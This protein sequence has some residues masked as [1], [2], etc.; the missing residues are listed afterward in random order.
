MGRDAALD[1]LTR[2]FTDHTAATLPALH[3]LRT[4]LDGKDLRG[5]ARGAAYQLLE[6]GAAFD[7]RHAGPA[8]QL[9]GE[10]RA[11][12]AAAGVK[13]GRVAA[14]LPGLLKP[15][16]AR[17]MLALRA[18]HSGKPAPA[19]PTQSS[20]PLADGSWTDATLHTAG[21]LRLGPRAVRADLAER[22]AVM[23]SQIRR[24]SETSAFAVPPELSAQ[25]GC[26]QADFPA[27]LRGLGLK[28]AE[29]DKETGAVKLWRFP[30][31]RT[32]QRE[33][34]RAR[35]AAPNAKPTP[36]P[37]PPRPVPTGPFAALAELIIM[38]PQPSRTDKP[39]R[40]RRHRRPAT[41]AAPK[42]AS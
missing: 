27:I 26:P 36:P 20:F 18:V 16:A 33:A 40:R 8:F 38:Q 28:P 13:S 31:Q 39:R 29:K 4:V 15:A 5:A 25:V 30:A 12:L 14:W 42:A 11:A 7:R 17:L 19:A 21:Y 22:L 32:P 9:T 35:P 37:P 24:G 23:L 10:D 2:W 34:K 3:H 6:T 41:A 1:R